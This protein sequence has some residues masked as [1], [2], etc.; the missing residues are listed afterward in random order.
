[1]TLSLRNRAPLTAAAIA[2]GAVYPFFV[3]FYLGNLPP[4]VF[5][6]CALVLIAVRV[7][8][9]MN[10]VLGRFVPITMAAAAA[11]LAA[12]AAIDRDAAARAY[13]VLMSLSTA[14]LFGYSLA[15]PPSL[16]ERMMRLRGAPP[17]PEAAAY[18]RKVTVLWAVTL[19]ANAAVSAATAIWGDLRVWTL[20]NGLLSYLVLGAVFAVEFAVRCHVRRAAE[21]GR[22]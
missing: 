1:M 22:A 12:T 11:A 5:V 9:S 6:L 7:A 21:A 17:S 20:Y 15:S 19:V 10:G 8:G 3:Y 18:M 2:L 13:P 16:I 14:A 4:G